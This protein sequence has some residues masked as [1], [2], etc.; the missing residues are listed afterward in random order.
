MAAV[1]RIIPLVLVCLMAALGGCALTSQPA[2]P[3]LA[4][5]TKEQA[6]WWEANQSRKQYVP[7]RGYYIDGTTGFFDEHGRKLPTEIA[8]GPPTEDASQEGFLDKIAPKKMYKKF[9][10]AIGKGPN[11][12]KARAALADGDALF[13]QREFS[14]AA[15]KYR[16][17]Y[18]RW[19]DSPLEEEALFKAGESEFFADRYR[20]ADDEYGMLTKKFPSTQY[21]GQVVVRRFS[22]GRYWEQ[23]DTAHP[24]W[25]VWPNFTDRTRPTFDTL[26]HALKV[27]ER[28]RL[29][30]PTGNL[31]DDSIMA[32]ANA[33]FLKGHWEDADYHYGLLRS[34]YPK[35]DFQYQ[36]HLLG[37]RCKLL[38]YQGPGYESAPLDEAE[39]L[40]TQLLAQFPQEL[41]AERERV[42]QVRGGIAAQ[43]AL[44]EWKMAEYYDKGKYYRASRHFYD[45]IV[46]EYPDTQLAQESRA[47]LEQIKD[48]PDNPTPPFEFITKWLPE[49]KKEG[50]VLPKNVTNVAAKPSSTTVR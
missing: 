29:D 13:R 14:K 17:A 19:P 21:L 43:R 18:D 6:E 7:G 10:V 35:S 12:N 9:K 25:P 8:G 4:P 26:G 37:L 5:L 47:R 2:P 41:G 16:L 46:K 38:R 34:E 49:S 24:H 1:S 30:D 11:E 36:A 3:A 23:Y 31:A 48:E 50:P 32:T 20:N 28:I 39:E 27:Y 40:A 44:A 42:A 33:H 15:K 45:K 22:I